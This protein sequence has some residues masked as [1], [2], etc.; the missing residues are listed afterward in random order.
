MT[1]HHVFVILWG[2]GSVTWRKTRRNQCW[3][4]MK[5][6]LSL[7]LPNRIFLVNWM[8]QGHYFGRKL[9]QLGW[10]RH[11]RYLL[12]WFIQTRWPHRFQ[13]SQRWKCNEL[14][15]FS[16]LGMATLCFVVDRMNS[17]GCTLVLG[18]AQLSYFENLSDDSFLIQQDN[19]RIHAS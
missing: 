7:K 12:A 5:N 18:D 19:T 1:P 14:G 3:K 9:V 10:A 6:Q 2:S 8:E 16:S 4:Q 17:E 13:K 11:V 15:I